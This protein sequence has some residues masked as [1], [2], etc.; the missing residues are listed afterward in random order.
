MF[1]IY[2]S[3]FFLNSTNYPTNNYSKKFHQYYFPQNMAVFYMHYLWNL[4][5]NSMFVCTNQDSHFFYVEI[6]L[7][8]S[9]YLNSVEN[10]YWIGCSI[11]TSLPIESKKRSFVCNIQLN[12][13]IFLHVSKALLVPIWNLSKYL[14]MPF[15]I[16]VIQLM[17]FSKTVTVICD[18]LASIFAQ[19]IVVTSTYFQKTVTFQIQFLYKSLFTHT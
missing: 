12:F 2:V 6:F 10:W 13:G 15:I 9:E 7:M 4:L 8:K 16:V 11:F 1:R 5:V 17:V 19:R 14:S 3:Y 18:I